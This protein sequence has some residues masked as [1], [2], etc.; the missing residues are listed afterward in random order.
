M[1]WDNNCVESGLCEQCQEC[2][3]TQNPEDCCDECRECR[4]DGCDHGQG[5]AAQP[6][7]T[8][9]YMWSV[10][11]QGGSHM[12]TTIIKLF[13]RTEDAV[14]VNKFF[15]CQIAQNDIEAI[16]LKPHA[17]EI[18]EAAKKLQAKEDARQNIVTAKI[19]A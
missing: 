17:K 14:L 1:A 10:D 15:S 19:V 3:G 5:Q 13:E 12:N 4:E 7:P 6:K 8:P 16:V 11:A 9:A 2:C 18:L